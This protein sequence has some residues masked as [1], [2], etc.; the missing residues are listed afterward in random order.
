MSTVETMERKISECLRG[1]LGLLRCLSNAVLYGK[2]NAVKKKNIVTRTRTQMPYRE[3]IDPKVSC[4]TRS[5][6]AANGMSQRV[7]SYLKY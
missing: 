1:W 6:R 2:L 4:L 7:K 5:N 3:S